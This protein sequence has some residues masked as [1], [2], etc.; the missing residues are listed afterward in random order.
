M[1][2]NI[3]IIGKK[4]FEKARPQLLYYMSIRK[5]D[6]S[7]SYQFHFIVFFLRGLIPDILGNRIVLYKRSY[8]HDL[9]KLPTRDVHGRDRT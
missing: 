8:M 6:W 2:I 9:Y 5:G 1:S 7:S 4:H 3:I